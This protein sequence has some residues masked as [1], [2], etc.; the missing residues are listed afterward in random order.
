MNVTAG[1]ANSR[2]VKIEYKITGKS[3]ETHRLN[4]RYGTE[5]NTS[6]PY[7]KEYSF[8]LEPIME[9]NADG[10]TIMHSLKF[11]PYSQCKLNKGL[12]VVK[13]KTSSINVKG[14]QELGFDCSTQDDFKAFW[15]MAANFKF[16]LNA[17]YAKQL[18]IG[19]KEAGL[20]K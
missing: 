14:Y 11:S 13:S 20:R 9:T 18:E 15:T 16:S 12:G 4:G 2:G 5:Y 7:A 6:T 19:L 10:K 8:W 17:A 3:F 1:E